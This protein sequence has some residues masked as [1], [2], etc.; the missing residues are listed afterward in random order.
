M[1][2]NLGSTRRPRGAKNERGAILKDVHLEGAVLKGADLTDADLT[3]AYLTGASL[4][5][6]DLRGVKWDAKTH[7]PERSKVKNA[8]NIPQKLKLQLGV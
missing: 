7:W 3:G 1:K 8:K 2:A 5:G 4:S 6:A